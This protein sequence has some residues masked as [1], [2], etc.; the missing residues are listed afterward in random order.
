MATKTTRK[1]A[2]RVQATARPVA[3]VTPI[4]IRENRELVATLIELLQEAQSGEIRGLL[5]AAHK[6]SRQHVIGATGSYVD[7]WFAAVAATSQMN[8]LA[9]RKARDPDE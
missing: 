8:F 9:N 7:D 1:P 6:V 4:L 2:L 5:F 3:S